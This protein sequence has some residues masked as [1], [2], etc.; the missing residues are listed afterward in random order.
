M[1]TCDMNELLIESIIENGQGE[2]DGRL[3]GCPRHAP[4]LVAKLPARIAPR[5]A[6]IHL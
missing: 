3:N 4:C 6:V 1:T 5:A 2:Q